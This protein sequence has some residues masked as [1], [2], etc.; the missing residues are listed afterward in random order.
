MTMSRMS[1]PFCSAK[2]KRGRRRQM[3]IAPR[4]DAPSLLGVPCRQVSL[5]AVLRR[6]LVVFMPVLALFFVSP[7]IPQEGPIF[8]TPENA[9]AAYLD[10]VA[11]RD[12][13]RVLAAT[14]L[15]RLYL[16]FDFAAYVESLGGVTPSVPAPASDPLL[17]EINKAAF[18]AGIAQQVKMLTYFLL[19]RWDLTQDRI[20]PLKPGD[21]AA[22]ASALDPRRLDDLKLIRVGTP[23]PKLMGDQKYQEH[24][25]Q[26]AAFFGAEEFTE[27]VA[28]IAFE[29]QTYEMGFQL[30]RFDG[31]WTISAQ[32]SPVG[33]T[34]PVGVP[35]PMTPEDFD[36]LLK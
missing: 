33:N 17:V 7:A 22:L 1:G 4:Q 6:V 5:E 18:A 9:V 8:S 27:R 26:R 34:S 31:G 25:V 19:R 30:M 35:W 20:V 2:D 14:A 10:G 24:A 21:G 13:G 3:E 16:D 15:E 11:Q 32:S 23:K 29:G 28:L 12:F 36:D